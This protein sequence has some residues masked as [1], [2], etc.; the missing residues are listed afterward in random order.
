MNSIENPQVESASR[1]S[2]LIRIPIAEF[3][4]SLAQ[5]RRWL[6]MIVVAGAFV[7]L[8]I[9]F[10]IPVQ[11]ASTVTLMPPDAST[12]T[13]SSFLNGLTGNATLLGS[14]ILRDE[15]TPGAIAIGVLSSRTV[16]DDLIKQFNLKTAYHAELDLDARTILAEHTKISQD[17]KDGIITIVVTDQNKYRARDI[18]QG[19]VSDLN[20]LINSLSS[21]SARREREFLEERLKLL[22]SDLEA[23]SIALSQFSSRNATFN[24]EQ[25]GQTVLGSASRMQEEL[26]TAQSDLSGL[27]AMYTDDNMHVRAAEARVEQLQAGLQKLTGEGSKQQQGGSAD[28]TLPSIRQV[29]L[30]GVKYLDLYRDVTLDTTLYETLTKQYELAK[31][32]EAKDIPQIKVL[33]APEVAERKSGPHRSHFLLGGMLISLFGGILWVIGPRLWRLAVFGASRSI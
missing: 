23:K 16:Q 5:R 24:P 21:S 12:F 2:V 10:L 32:E 1:E 3:W 30:L 33:D 27:K 29:P 13:S 4:E 9:S 18:A 26:I 8:G 19:Y 22:N 15:S 28:D 14:S 20:H 17:E 11:Y 7:S 25:Q 31:A 6:G